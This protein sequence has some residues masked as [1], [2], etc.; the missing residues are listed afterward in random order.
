MDESELVSLA[1]KCN[2]FVYLFRHASWPEM[3][4]LAFYLV[5]NFEVFSIFNLAKREFFN[6]HHNVFFSVQ[7][8]FIDAL[9]RF[10]AF[11]FIYNYEVSSNYNDIIFCK[12]A[13]LGKERIVNPH[14]TV[15][16]FVCSDV[17]HWCSES[18]F[19]HLYLFCNYE[20][21]SNYYP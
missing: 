10:F 2:Y 5:W 11:C 16:C 8:Y 7:T 14:V 15:F 12:P 3:R 19:L 13:G 6:L 18:D 9:M 17:F 21:S 1:P 20:V 4:W